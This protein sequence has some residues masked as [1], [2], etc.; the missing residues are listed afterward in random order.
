[1]SIPRRS[2]WVVLIAVLVASWPTFRA[3]ADDWPQW[4]GPNRDGV[5]HETGI[6]KKFEKPQLDIKWRVAVGS[7]Y[8]GPTVAGGS[9]FVT[10]R[11]V[12]P[13]QVER[14]HCFDESTG[15]L[16]WTHAYDCSYSG[17][18]YD[19]GPRTSVHIDDGRAYSLGT[20]GNFLA[21]DADTGKVI[22]QKDLNA[23]YQIRMPIWG[24]S[25]APV[26]EGEL[27]IVQI[28][29]EG[30]ACLVA[31]DKV[32]GKEAW[33]AISDKPSYAAPIVIDQAGK[34]V[35][36]CY[37][38]ENIVGLDPQT[39]RKYW[40]YP[41]PPSRMAIGIADPVLHGDKLFLTSFF[42]GSL[43]LKLG[44]KKT[45]IKKVWHRAGESEKKTDAIHSIISTPYLKGDYIYGI[46]S[47]GELRCLELK[48][49]DRVWESLDVMPRARWATAHLTPHGDEVWLFNERGE[50]IISELS[51]EGYKEISRAQLIKPT[52]V[53]L[54][55]RG[56][57]CW[58][59]PAFAN[60]HI[61]ARNDEE[62][63]CASLK[64]K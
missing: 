59:H 27:I 54:R 8:A 63:V 49:G 55:R 14:I 15:S 56:G 37:T 45:T 48:T 13:K 6:I 19:A 2:A 62:L 5:W 36:V 52:K 11:L 7:G 41:F 17:V 50:L 61:F 1:M 25:A 43:L 12:E 60:G 26:I 51:P 34:R 30:D 46:D 57:V 42:E 23:E 53:Q 35:L 58:S 4:R 38:G 9:V 40:S 20:M 47:Y 21:L 16:R 3:V 39:G 64:A 31:F 33:H 22:W 44:K 28:G 18:Q 10:D 32:T 24:I 29:G